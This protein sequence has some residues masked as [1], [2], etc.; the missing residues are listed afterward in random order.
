MALRAKS[1]K[2]ALAKGPRGSSKA[3]SAENV[4]GG[5]ISDANS[6][7]PKAESLNVRAIALGYY[8]A[9]LREEGDTFDLREAEHFSSSWME[10]V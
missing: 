4:S 2:G 5:G 7:V 6:T 10:R 9:Q 3:V 8:G 1:A